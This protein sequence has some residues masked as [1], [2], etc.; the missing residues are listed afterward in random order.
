M[1]SLSAEETKK[2]CSKEK[3]LYKKMVCKTD[4]VTSGVTSKKTLADFFKKKK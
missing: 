1:T 4:N 2:D 3:S